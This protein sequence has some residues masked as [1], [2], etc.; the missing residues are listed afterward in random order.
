MTFTL[1]GSGA[2]PVT[3]DKRRA[4]RFKGKSATLS[5]DITLRPGRRVEYLDAVVIK[6]CTQVHAA[7]KT[8]MVRVFEKGK[9]LTAESFMDRMRELMGAARAETS[10]SGFSSLA[11]EIGSLSEGEQAGLKGEFESTDP[12]TLRGNAEIAT[13]RGLPRIAHAFSSLADNQE[14]RIRLE[15]ELAESK[16]KEA[17]LEATKAALDPKPETLPAPAED[18]A[19]ET[20]VVPAP[21]VPVDLVIAPEPPTAP[22]VVTVVETSGEGDAVTITEAA[23]EGLTPG[24]PA[25]RAAMLPADWRARTKDQLVALATELDIPM[26]EK[27]TKA[28]M[29]MAVE[30]W[31]SA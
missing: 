3:R 14:E 21:E 17:E 7:M 12:T 10:E 11:E 6:S 15:K 27:V 30:S 23:P 18:A 29:V 31:L 13:A 4:A 28:N 1:L 5:A 2:D 16:A 24:E 22:P 26:P 19:R 9:E 8:G 25:D 20:P